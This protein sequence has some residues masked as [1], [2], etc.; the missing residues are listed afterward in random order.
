MYRKTTELYGNGAILLRLNISPPNRLGWNPTA[1]LTN[2]LPGA[3]MEVNKI[4][5]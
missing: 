2:A 3:N 4:L 5:L 1:Q